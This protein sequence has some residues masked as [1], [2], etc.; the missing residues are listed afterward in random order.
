MAAKQTV[1]AHLRRLAAVL[2]AT[3][4]DLDSFI[5]ALPVDGYLGDALDTAAGRRKL[6]SLERFCRALM[7][8]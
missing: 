3:K 2:T 1:P 7:G 8:P 6:P 5:K 4:G